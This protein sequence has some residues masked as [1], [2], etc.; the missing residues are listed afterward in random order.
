MPSRTTHT[1]AALLV[2][3][4]VVATAPAPAQAAPRRSPTYTKVRG[5]DVDRTTIPRLQRLMN[6]HRLT[7]AQLTAFYLRRIERLNPRLHAVIRVSPTAL[8]DAR[9]ADAAR[10]SGR[11]LPLLRIPVIAKDNMGTTPKT[12]AAR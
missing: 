3:G 10:R 12:T 7:S 5:I 9:A 8:R 2:S 1:L 6:R 11:R 4:L